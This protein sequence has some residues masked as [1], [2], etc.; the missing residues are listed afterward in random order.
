MEKNW[1]RQS[2]I[3]SLDRDTDIENKHR[4]TKGESG[5][6]GRNW[7]IRIDIYTVDTMYKIDRAS[8]GSDSKE[9]AC[10][11]GDLGSIPALGRCL[12]ERNGNP[13]QCS[14]LQNSMDRG[15]W[16]ANSPWSRKDLDM[17]E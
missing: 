10:S 9:S 15:A 14:S 17:N 16:R 1:Y 2:Y 7:E 8:W 13:L 5:G 12:G 4:D 6:D 11:A 3:Q